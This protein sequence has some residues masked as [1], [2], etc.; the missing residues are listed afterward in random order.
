MKRMIS[1]LFG[2]AVLGAIGCSRDTRALDGS[3]W[4]IIS[5]DDFQGKLEGDYSNLGPMEFRNGRIYDKYGE[6]RMKGGYP[7]VFD[8][9]NVYEGFYDPNGAN[10]YDGNREHPSLIFTNG[11]LICQDCPGVLTITYQ[12]VGQ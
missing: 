1:A 3:K 4:K 11:Q 5:M 12:K 10:T 9:T 7:Y 2:L 8:G 6:A